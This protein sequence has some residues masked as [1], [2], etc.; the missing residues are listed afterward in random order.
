MTAPSLLERQARRGLTAA[1]ALARIR[2]TPSL[3]GPAPLAPGFYITT[4]VELDSTGPQLV[5]CPDCGRLR[6]ASAHPHAPRYEAVGSARRIDCSGR[7][8]R[9]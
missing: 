3:V 2:Q 4:A 1:E 8:V 9:R 6:Y 7:E 5:A